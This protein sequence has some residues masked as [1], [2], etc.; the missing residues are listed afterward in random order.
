MEEIIIKDEYIKLGQALK[1][2][3]AVGSGVDAKYVINEGLVKVNGEICCQRGRKLKA[4]GR[5]TWK[6]KI[7]TG[8][9]GADDPNTWRAGQRAPGTW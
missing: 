3:N 5:W 4:E 2:S 6:R 9:A 8:S 1:L 7:R